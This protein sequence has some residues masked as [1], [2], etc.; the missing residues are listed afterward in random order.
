M[1]LGVSVNSG[2]EDDK[3]STSIT[4][5]C[6]NTFS[7]IHS[8]KTEIGMLGEEGGIPVFQVRCFVASH[9]WGMIPYRRSKE[10]GCVRIGGNACG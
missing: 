8:Q 10:K 1:Y 5:K 7:N 6:K 9:S 2:E 4:F 3:M